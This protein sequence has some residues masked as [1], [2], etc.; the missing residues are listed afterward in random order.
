[1][2]TPQGNDGINRRELKRAGQDVETLL[3]STIENFHSRI[4]VQA[5]EIAR[6]DALP[7]VTEAQERE[8]ALTD[9]RGHLDSLSQELHRL[10]EGSAWSDL[11]ARIQIWKMSK[12]VRY[13]RAEHEQA[14]ARFESPEE[15]LRRATLIERHNDEVA[16]QRDRL[17]NLQRRLDDL[18]VL[19]KTL[20]AFQQSSA[21]AVAAAQNDGWIASTFAHH[22]LGIAACVRAEDFA[23]ANRLLPG[24]VF[25]RKPKNET[26]AE[27]RSEAQA[28]LESAYIDYAGFATS[29]AYTEIAERSILQALPALRVNASSLLGKFSHPADQWHMLAATLTDPLAL[30]TDAL[31]AV[32]WAMFQCSQNFARSLAQSD[33]REDFLTGKL[34]THLSQWLTEWGTDRIRR[35]GYPASR[36]YMGILEIASSREETRLGADLGVIVDIDVGGLT[37]RKVAL[38]QAKK[39]IDGG[40]N[41]GSDSM[42][43]SKLSQQPQL[44]YYIFYHQATHPRLPPAATV[45]SATEL[46]E[47]DDV[48]K[49][50]INARHLP[51]NVRTLG[52]DFAGFVSF[53][54]CRSDS[55]VGLPFNDA[56]DALHALSG[57]DPQH[58]PKYLQVIAIADEP[59]VR[60]LQD[61]IKKVYRQA[62][63]EI[64]NNRYEKKAGPEKHRF[65]R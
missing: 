32:H 61:E 56:K 17:P 15:R 42:Q 5:A 52:W 12:L 48:T 41:V 11:S 40:T 51:I 1:M 3:A 35:F 13:A 25:Q 39:A 20:S 29:S 43:L 23:E 2:D 62:T 21:Q 47:S 49:R 36:S 37:C 53:G 6:I 60:A 33:A 26:Y 57:G 46:A 65:Q 14:Q 31:W 58:L 22:F 19:N 8:I 24:L 64:T 28:I 9:T 44:G 38:L 27:L 50:G 10:K 59:R 18:K 34:T 54:L 16:A 30:A 45:C 63:M 55:D 4:R 7:L